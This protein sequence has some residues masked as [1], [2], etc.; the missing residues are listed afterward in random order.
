M[1]TTLKQDGTRVT[2]APADDPVA[3]R[4]ELQKVFDDIG[5]IWEKHG[6]PSGVFMERDPDILPDRTGLYR[7]VILLDTDIAI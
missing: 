3:I 2:I 4:H 6:G 7:A 1:H 5:A